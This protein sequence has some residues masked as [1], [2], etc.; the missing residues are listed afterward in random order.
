[1]AFETVIPLSGIYP[2]KIIQK[3]ENDLCVK[4]YCKFEGSPNVTVEVF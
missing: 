4:T 1:M 3:T 2:K